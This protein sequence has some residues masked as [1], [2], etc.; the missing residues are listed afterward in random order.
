MRSATRYPA[1]FPSGTYGGPVPAFR[2]L[3]SQSNRFPIRAAAS[4]SESKPAVGGETVAAGGP[5]GASWRRRATRSAMASASQSSSR[6]TATDGTR[7]DLLPKGV[8]GLGSTYGS[9]YASRHV[10]NS[11]VF[12][13][14]FESPPVGVGRQPRGGF[15]CGIGEFAKEFWLRGRD[16]N[17]RPLG[18]EPNELTDCLHPASTRQLSYHPVDIR[19]TRRTQNQPASARRRLRNPAGARRRT[20][21][22]RRARPAG[23]DSSAFCRGGNRRVAAPGDF[24]RD[25]ADLPTVDDNRDRLAEILVPR[26]GLKDCGERGRQPSDVFQGHDAGDNRNA[27]EN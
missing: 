3:R 26:L 21:R 8:P 1:D 11:M 10:W 5:S 24:G 2:R 16:L 6:L 25:V 4:G 20:P 18:Y 19:S 7:L 27:L 9:T 23:P 15:G 22:G 17:P 14:T 12:I 13:G